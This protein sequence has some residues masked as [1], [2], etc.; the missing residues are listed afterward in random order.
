[1]RMLLKQAESR[2]RFFD[3]QDVVSGPDILNL[4]SEFTKLNPNSNI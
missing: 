4:K 3:L 2:P 1:M